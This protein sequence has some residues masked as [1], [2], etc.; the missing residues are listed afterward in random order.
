MAL[1][2]LLLSS[3]CLGVRLCRQSRLTSVHALAPYY[4]AIPLS[5][6][7]RV[8]F[9]T[10]IPSVRPHFRFPMYPTPLELDFYAMLCCSFLQGDLSGVRKTL[11]PF[12]ARQVADSRRALKRL[13]LDPEGF[14][15]VHMYTLKKVLQRLPRH[16]T[17]L[18]EQ[19]YVGAARQ[20]RGWL[21]ACV[22]ERG[23]C[24]HS[25]YT[26]KLRV[27]AGVYVSC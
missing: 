15:T 18:T 24:A 19:R 3:V 7:R 13:D 8:F 12:T 4:S 23:D 21:T 2:V 5:A 17:T 22:A 14:T 9:R 16:V 10:F 27:V 25:M 20:A 1:A 6:I 11:L 26:G